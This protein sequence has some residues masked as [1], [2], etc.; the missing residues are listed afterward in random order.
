MNHLTSLD[1][2][3]RKCYYTWLHYVGFKQH[4]SH[5]DFNWNYDRDKLNT[6]S[7]DTF[8]KRSDVQNFARFVDTTPN[9]RDRQELMVS[10][11]IL[12]PN[13][14]VIDIIAPSD[15]LRE[16][17]GMRMGVV[18]SLAYHLRTE[19]DKIDDFL[20]NENLTLIESLKVSDLNPS[21]LIVKHSGNIGISLETLSALNNFFNYSRFESLSPLWNKNR[22][23]IAK[24]GKLLKFDQ[25][26]MKSRID[27]LL[28]SH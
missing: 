19:L 27:T 21:P 4:F 25:T 13:S 9:M 26:W 11:F 17:H 10:A 24:Y 3:N 28:Q 16:F 1:S 8:F 23:K 15:S 5:D 6:I 2:F 12:N 14:Y 20:Y 7:P 22:L 18:S